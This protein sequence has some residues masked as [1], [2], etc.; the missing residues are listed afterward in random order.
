M[1]KI[2]TLFL[3]I[4]SVA[5]VHAQDA[6]REEARR[7]I[8]GEGSKKQEQRR[9]E[10]PRDVINGG[11]NGGDEGT[12]PNGGSREARIDAINRDYDAKIYSVRNNPSLSAEEKEKAIRFLEKDRAR[13]IKQVNKNNRDRN[14]DDD[15]YDKKDKKEN[16]GKHKG[17][18]KGKGHQK[19]KHKGHDH[20]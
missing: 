15:R 1:K 20:D 2:I 9:N 18:T 3:A 14:D 4:T 7:I 13:K 8:L 11:N 6:K 10:N 5:A 19:N 17:W 12:Y 16:K